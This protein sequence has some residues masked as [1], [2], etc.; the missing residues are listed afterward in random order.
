MSYCDLH[1]DPSAKNL[2]VFLEI[3]RNLGLECASASMLE[4]AN[5]WSEFY[6]VEHE[7][8]VEMEGEQKKEEKAKFSEELEYL[9]TSI[10][11]APPRMKK[12]KYEK[13][14]LGKSSLQLIFKYCR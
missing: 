8:E 9:E 3:M 13:I 12:M 4:L 1:L 11:M 5:K 6:C 10:R 7:A 14:Y 2:S